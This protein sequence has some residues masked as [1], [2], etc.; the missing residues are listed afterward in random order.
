M[1]KI[2][3]NK[4]YSKLTDDDIDNICASRSCC[5]C[6]LQNT[7]YCTSYVEVPEDKVCKCE[8]EFKLYDDVDDLTITAEEEEAF[9]S[10]L[11]QLIHG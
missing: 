5:D 4:P 3:I 9:K 8:I 6:P 10:V 11:S 1:T 2:I 7:K